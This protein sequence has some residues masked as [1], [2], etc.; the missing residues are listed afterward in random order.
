M[1][2]KLTTIN[3]DQCKFVVNKKQKDY[4]YFEK[5]NLIIFIYGYPFNSSTNHWISSNDVYQMY[6]K[7]KF[8]FI[9]NIEGIYSILI[10][11]KIKNK[12]FLIT[13]RY[14]I[15][16]LFY[17]K[18]N[19]HIIISDTIDE[20]INHMQ[21]IKLNKGSIIEYL[22]FG[23]KLGNKTHIE[24]IYEFES[25]AIYQINKE[26]E[27]AEEFYWNI[28]DLTEKDKLTNEKFQTIFNEHVLTAM[29]LSE[30]KSLPLTGGLDTRTILSACLPKMERLHCYT[31]GP[32]NHGDIKLAQKICEH[33]GIK[34]NSYT[35]D[36]NWI[37]KLPSNLEKNALI[38]NG[39]F[40]L[41]YLHVIE[42]FKKESLSQ[43]LFITGVLGNQLFRHHPFGNK[44]VDSIDLNDISLFII[45]NL[46]S[47]LY[48]KTDLTSY[49]NNLFIDYNSKETIDLIRDS[50][51][52]E[53]TKA[54]NVKKPKDLT[55]FFLFKT[56]CSNVASHSL[57]LTGKYFKVFSPFFHKDLLQQIHFMSLKE[58]T[59]G[60]I[61]KYIIYKNNSYLADLPYTPSNRF[62]KYMKLFIYKVSKKLL[63]KNIINSPLIADYAEWM[64]NYHKDFLLNI[65]D[66]DK[67][68][69]KGFFRKKEFEQIVEL[70]LTDNQS[71]TNK[72]E[73]LLAYSIEK[74]I[75]NIMSLEIW[76][77]SI[78]KEKKI[79]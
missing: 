34:Y 21:Q 55:E 36:E 27:I 56:Y 20:I 66:Y 3:W 38:F 25:S 10:F 22:N 1:F 59:Q 44:I 78:N 77:R 12:Y 45:Q 46:P 28:L 29:T 50:I 23:F 58:K 33:F 35:W 42:S 43:E 13:D 74:F 47:V 51:K 48:F 5:S 61:Q 71:L 76:L 26:L 64:R 24:G 52:I 32:K 68:I 8:D 60:S 57:K 54:K 14:G 17:L 49:Y 62:L 31:H 53:L 72:K 70:F 18:N 69:T 6:L 37:K 19:K 79:T 16:N 2:L 4:D 11:D 30:K 39:L 73:I 41:G 67:M 7:S 75:L 63:K 65:L 40:S 9:E 15:Y